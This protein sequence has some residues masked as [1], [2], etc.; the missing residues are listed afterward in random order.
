MNMSEQM[1]SSKGQTPGTANT[2]KAIV[3]DRYGSVDVYRQERIALPEVAANEVLV[4]VH[5]AGMDRGTWHMMTGRP[6]LIRILG[7][8]VRGPK[9]RVPGLDVAGT[10]VAVGS[11]VSRFSVGDEVFGISRGSF[12]EYAAVLE[13]KLAHKPS[14]L[15]FEQA[16]VVPISAGTALQALDA[17]KVER[18][19]KVLILGASGG[20]GTFAVQLAKS[21]GAEVTGVCSTGKVDLV[22]SLGADHVLDYTREDFADGTRRYDL[23]LDIG[24]NPPL[25]RLRRALAPGGTAIIVGGESGGKWTGGFGRNLRAPLFSLFV[26]ERLAMLASKERASDLEQ[27]APLIEAGQVMP[28]IDTVYKLEEVPQAMGQLEAGRVRGKIAI[29]V[30]E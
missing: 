1:N 6:Y 20:V 24:G 23:I 3:Q 26:R 19:Q 22:R 5:A 18:G 15:S 13:E 8:G 17:G 30:S 2:M 4:R 12:A 14:N 10:V 9:N 7:F 11:E 27:L 21:N 28:S 29:H 16:A 25:S